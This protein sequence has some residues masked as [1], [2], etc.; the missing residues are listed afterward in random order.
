MCIHGSLL[1]RLLAVRSPSPRKLLM[2]DAALEG[3]KEVFK[4][5][6][7]AFGRLFSRKPRIA[8]AIL[9]AAAAAILLCQESLLKKRWKKYGGQRH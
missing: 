1:L 3:G 2:I 7:V 8:R 6:P 9:I 4:G 5:L